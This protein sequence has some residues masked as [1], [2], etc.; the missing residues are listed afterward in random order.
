M[1]N[2]KRYKMQF[3][4]FVLF[5]AIVLPLII[6][7]L[8]SNEVKGF[9]YGYTIFMEIIMAYLT[10]YIIE[11]R[12]TLNTL[13]QMDNLKCIGKNPLDTRGFKIFYGILIIFILAMYSYSII[14]GDAEFIRSA[15]IMIV[16]LNNLSLSTNNFY[17]GDKFIVSGDRIV[18]RE[19]IMYIKTRDIVKKGR[20][21]YKVLSIRLKND[22]LIEIR[23]SPEII[24]EIQKDI[25]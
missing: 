16:P 25:Y 1:D 10:C 4:L 14:T 11:T 23:R 19:D 18:L 17:I 21:K 3:M 20:L 7:F 24:A 22:K 12:I 15:W 13:R 9:E 8:N 6:Y 5:E 2:K